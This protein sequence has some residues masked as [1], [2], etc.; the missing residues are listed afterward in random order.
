LNRAELKARKILGDTSNMELPVMLLLGGVVNDLIKE[1]KGEF[2]D[3]KQAV[4]RAKSL[5]NFLKQTNVDQEKYDKGDDIAYCCTGLEMAVKEV[6]ND[7]KHCIVKI[8]SERKNRWDKA[9]KLKKK[10]G[11]PVRLQAILS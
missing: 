5:G 6:G 8:L 10:N 4:D 3:L 2:P 7:V 1:K 9:M 11:T